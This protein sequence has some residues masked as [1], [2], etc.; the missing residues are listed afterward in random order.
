MFPVIRIRSSH[1]EAV[2]Y[3][4]TKA[5]FWFRDGEQQMLFKAEERG[6]GEDW[7]EKIACELCTLLGLPHVHYEMAYDLD[8]QRPGVVC[9]S[10][11]P[12][13][14]AL[15]HGNQ[16]LLALDPAYP[17]GAEN[18]YRSGQ[19]LAVARSELAHTLAATDSNSSRHLRRLSVARCLDR[20]SGS[21][22]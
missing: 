7:A 1:A 10:C 20:E 3:L 19:P 6:T 8:Q 21:A 14:L 16:L 9:A 5:K 13:P 11:A 2:E 18:R 15:A 17:A 22:P 12:P 4:G